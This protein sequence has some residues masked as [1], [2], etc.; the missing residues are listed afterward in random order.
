[1]EE[2]YKTN[3]WILVASKFFHGIHFFGPLAVLYFREWLGVSYS[4]MFLAQIVFMLSSVLFEI[5]TGWVADKWG[6][7]VSIIIGNIIIALSLFL[8]VFR[9]YPLVVLA[10]F[11]GGFGG[12]FISGAD[13]ALLYD[14]MKK[15]GVK[16]TRKW[17]A[18]MKSAGTAGIMVGNLAGPLLSMVSDKYLPLSFALTGILW[19]MLLPALLLLKEIKGNV[20]DPIKEGIMGLKFL[21]S[22]LRKETISGII[23]MPLTFM[24]FWLYQPALPAKGLPIQYLGLVS[25]SFN[26]ISMLFTAIEMNLALAS[27]LASLSF[28]AFGLGGLAVSIIASVAIPAL[29][30]SKETTL[31]DRITRSSPPGKRA[32]ILSALSLSDAFVRM[33]VYMLIGKLMDLSLAHASAGIAISLAVLGLAELAMKL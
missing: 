30:A 20:E 12:T 16:E 32:T 9:S 17:M 10:E 3:L 21:F 25:V 15:A 26:A 14:S 11:L 19:L 31:M 2:N 18:R 13:K 29:R 7:K 24:L 33:F 6:R 23:F 8:F 4:Q 5:P 22:S 27:F 28:L 1:M